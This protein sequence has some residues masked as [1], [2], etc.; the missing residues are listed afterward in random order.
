MLNRITLDIKNLDLKKVLDLCFEKQPFDYKIR[1]KTVLITAK[2]RWD[3]TLWPA[4]EKWQVLKGVVRDSATNETLIGV[5][6]MVEGTKTGAVTDKDGNFTISH[7]EP[8]FVLVISY[9][10]YRTEKISISGQQS[11]EIKM[12]K[13]NT[14]LNEVVVV[15]YGT[16]VKGAITG[17]ISTVKSDVFENRPLNNSLDALQGTVPG[18]TITKGSGQ[19]GNQSYGI[20]IRGYS[21][22]NESNP[23]MLID[24][25][26]GDIDNI[27]PNDIAEISVLKDASA[28]IYGA[29]AADGVIIVTTKKEKAENRK[30]PIVVQ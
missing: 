8:N 5:S 29:R 25:I 7:P 26:P 11:I 15:G 18:L 30:L 22:V 17:A 2:R 4:V 1:N 10:G 23:L 12:S 19:P 13:M 24:G 9:L 6:I 27:N 20:K 3:N 14:S 28:A 21:S 16:R